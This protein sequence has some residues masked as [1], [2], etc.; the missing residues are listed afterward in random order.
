M[1]QLKTHFIFP[2]TWDTS[3]FCVYFSAYLFIDIELTVHVCL[4]QEK[5][6]DFFSLSTWTL[7]IWEFESP[8]LSVDSDELR[9]VI[10]VHVYEEEGEGFPVSKPV[11]YVAS[12]LWKVRQLKK[13]DPDRTNVY[14]SAAIELVSM[15]GIFTF[16][17][18]F[19]P[20]KNPGR[21]Y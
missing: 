7:D 4:C 17:L 5:Q 14:W 13:R 11:H 1:C 16:S 21:W 8:I 15:L 10:P 12:Q 6:V 9:A 18:E 2:S 19:N 20:H 3:F